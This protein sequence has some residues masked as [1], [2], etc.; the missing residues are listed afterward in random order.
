M[1][2]DGGKCNQFD[3]G[4]HRCLYVDIFFSSAIVFLKSREIESVLRGPF[5]LS[6]FSL[7][8]TFSAVLLALALHYLEYKNP[9]TVSRD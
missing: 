6:R 5:F 3:L 8:L 2:I 9:L 7:V 1:D 4:N